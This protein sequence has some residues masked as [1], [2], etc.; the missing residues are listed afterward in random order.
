M[1]WLE[2]ILHSLILSSS[3][4][5]RS[6]DDKGLNKGAWTAEEDEKL[7]TYINKYG[8]W[9]W[10]KM[11]PYA[12]LSRTGKSCRLRWMN[13]LKPNIKRGNFTSEEKDT[14][15]Y[16]HSIYGNRWSAIARKLPG[17][18]DNEVKNYWHT[19]LKK[20]VTKD[21]MSET[22][23]A[24]IKTLNNDVESSIE[25]TTDHIFSGITDDHDTSSC[26]FDIC[27]RCEPKVKFETNFNLSSPRTVED[28]ESFWQQLYSDNEDFKF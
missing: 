2:S 5:L 26:L 22:K 18:T 19:H 11:P 12:G 21:P 6:R 28:V 8:I 9:N 10:C 23:P 17:R 13:Y 27:S 7:I 3:L 15:I 20:Q 4:Y 25:S 1:L 14:I 24:E 16:H